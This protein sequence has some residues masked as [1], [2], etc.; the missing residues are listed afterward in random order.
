M[1]LAALVLA[2]LLLCVPAGALCAG[3]VQNADFSEVAEEL[4]LYWLPDMWDTTPG[5]TDFSVDPDGLHGNSAHLRCDAPNDAR[6]VQ[7]VQVTPNTVY[8]F[9]AMVKASGCD[10]DSVG[11]NLSVEDALGMSDEAWDTDGEW[12]ELAMYGRTGSGQKT[13][14]LMLR[15]GGYGALSTGEAWFDDVTFEPVTGAAVGATIHSLTPAPRGEEEASAEGNT[16]KYTPLF[17]M[18]S[19]LFAIAFL[20]TLRKPALSQ[21]RLPAHV[22]TGDHQ[23]L[24]P[25]LLC[26]LGLAL[27]VRLAL[28][29]LVDGYPTDINCWK[30]WSLRMAEAGPL[31]FYTDGYFCDYPPGYMYV[32]WVVGG[33]A[34]LFRLTLDSRA[35]T[36]LVKLPAIAADILCGLVLY[37]M[38]KGPYGARKAIVL[39]A[40]YL[41]NPAVLVNSAAWGQ[42]DAILV[43]FLLLCLEG[44]MHGRMMRASLWYAVAVLVKPQALMFGPLLLF[45]F[46]QGILEDRGRGWLRLAQCFFAAIGLLLAAS[47]P[48]LV[49]A[50]DPLLLPGKYFGTMASYPYASLS[51][52]NLFGLIGGNWTPQDEVPF[53]LSWAQWGTILMALTLLGTAALW[54]FS[55]DRY[56]SLPLVG[57]VLVLGLYTFGLRMHE[58]YMFPALALLLMAYGA[59]GDR[60][61]LYVFGLLSVPQFMNVALT[62][63]SE[64]ILDPDKL[65]LIMFSAVNV[66]A[67]LYLIWVSVDVLVRGRCV[68]GQGQCAARAQSE[69]QA[70]EEAP[71][72]FALPTLGAPSSG[73]GRFLDRKDALIMLALTAVYAAVALVNLGSHKAPQTYWQSS[74][75]GEEVVFDLG[76]ARQV[77]RVYYYG[78]LNDGSFDIAFSADGLRYSEPRACKYGENTMFMWF[79]QDL[80]AAGRGE[81]AR[82]V[83]LSPGRAGLWLYEMAFADGE[84]NLYPVSALSQGGREGKTMDPSLLLDEQDTVPSAPSYYNSMYFDEIYHARTAFEQNHNME[85]Y[86]TTHPPLGKVFISWSESLLGMNPFAWRL[87]GTLAGIFMVPVMYALAAFFFR[88]RRISFVLGVMMSFDFMHFAQTRLATIDSFAVLFIMLMYLFMFVYMTRSS[89]HE[90]LAKTLPPLALSGVFM[91]LGV[92]SKWICIYAGLG[93]ALL[94]FYSLGARIAEW[95]AAGRGGKDVPGGLLHAR[96]VRE[97][98]PRQ[99]LLT[100]LVCIVCFVVVPACI[101]LASYYQ[102]VRIPTPGHDLQGILDAQASMFDYHSRLM[103]SHPFASPWWEWPLII[104][105][106]WLYM[107]EHLRPGYV[108]SINTMG[109][110][111]V[112]WA[113]LAGLVYV[114]YRF[115]SGKARAD[116]R[117]ALVLIGFA[118]QF[119]PWVLVPRSTFIYHYFASVPF[120]ILC[121]GFYFEQLLAQRGWAL[122]AL[123][124]YCGVVVFLFAFFY[125]ILSGATI[126]IEYARLLRWIPSWSLFA[127]A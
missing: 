96:Q 78:F 66:A 44:Y 97:R 70:A 105:P 42:I 27:A 82:F 6:F 43:L 46:V 93:L 98:Y 119:L 50:G 76:E 121:C 4:P 33:I 123:L 88:D 126:P 111:F 100:L 24:L 3:L 29:F 56:K 73:R 113:G 38:L 59:Y 107:G 127:G 35:F 20:W 69:R 109:S 75:P 54:W 79:M 9:T 65:W 117:V 95:R 68:L 31:R 67:M 10:Q 92:A 89:H 26:T 81:T 41:F 80:Q 63:Q 106:M 45:V 112:W 11:A 108:A 90:P 122:R 22:E 124:A 51:A 18:I 8:R 60:R 53:L 83:K 102:Y 12:V 23:G 120:I 14:T 77:D 15:I 39:S 17:L 37:R 72:P 114:L 7:K 40:L 118:A 116:A 101:Y 48:F 62:L 104:R 30:L 1:A 110:P 28:G 85:W 99:M 57:A 21:A 55:R 64:H 87:P 94:F 25:L 16:R 115:I 13:L 49:L 52:F 32:L 84:G 2:G 86:E 61:L 36:L 58:R 74:A 103:D 125:P 34:N 91:G 5:M 19:L 47:L 71:P